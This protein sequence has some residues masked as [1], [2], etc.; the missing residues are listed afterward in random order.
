EKAAPV[1]ESLNKL[2]PES[3]IYQSGIEKKE[4]RTLYE[5]L[6]EVTGLILISDEI[7]SGCELI[8]G[9][10]C[11]NKVPVLTNASIDKEVL[12][13]FE[14]LKCVKDIDAIL[15]YLKKNKKKISREVQKREALKYLFEK[16]IPYSPDHFSK[17]IEKGNLEICE[18]YLAAGM[19]VNSRDKDGTPMLNIAVRN[20]NAQLVEWLLK[21]GAE[22]NPVSEDRGYTPLMDAVWRKNEEITKLLIDKGADVNVIN[23]EGQT[24]IILSVGSENLEITRLLCQAGADADIQDQMGMSAYGYASL[25]KKQKILEILEK[26]HK[27][28]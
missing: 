12:D 25:F 3:I 7:S 9:Y 20:D 21:N 18:C 8:V 23:K 22:L 17:Y 16:G 26:Y 1:K 6:G 2:F 13:C 14:T 15:S 27:E 5:I 4:V 19:D 24:M 28:D 10:L 11:G